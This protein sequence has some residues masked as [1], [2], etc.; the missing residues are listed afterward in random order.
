MVVPVRNENGARSI[1]GHARGRAERGRGRAAHHTINKATCAPRCAQ[2]RGH[3]AA[4]EGHGAKGIIGLIR[5]HK[6]GRNGGGGKGAGH[7]E[8]RSG[9]HAISPPRCARA[10]KRR[11]CEPRVAR[12]SDAVVVL[13]RNVK[14][15]A[16]IHRDARGVVELRRGHHR[17]H[18]AQR[19]ARRQGRPAAIQWAPRHSVAHSIR[20]VQHGARGTYRKTRGLRK[21]AHKGG[22]GPIGPQQPHAAAVAVPRYHNLG[23][24][25]PRCSGGGAAQGR[26]KGVK[27][28]RRKGRH[29]H[30]P[31]NGGIRGGAVRVAACRGAIAKHRGHHSAAARA[32]HGVCKPHTVAPTVHHICR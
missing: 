29:A 3:H 9:A 22:A 20:N 23:G 16:R 5:H 31:A 18:I 28:R 2:Q 4:W 17:V 30:G 25:G 10:R 27:S 1:D 6:R 19:S 11:H 7:A 15:A 21:P 8:A 26:S 32:A 14:H 24:G 13:I 12:H